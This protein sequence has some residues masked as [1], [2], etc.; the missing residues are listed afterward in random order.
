MDPKLLYDLARQAQKDGNLAEAERLYRQILTQSRQAE[1]LVNLGN[2]LAAQG[3]REEALACHDE[4]LA[5]RPELFEA[6]Y[7]RANLLLELNRA[8]EALQAFDGAIALRP[9]FVSGWN[10]RGTALRRLRKLDEALA[11]F[12]RAAVLA[13]SHVNALTNCAIVLSDLGRLDQALQ[14]ADAA[15]AVQPQSAEAL[16]IK[17][18]ILRDLDRPEEARDCFGRVL[19]IAP[20]HG[21]ALS[22][23]AQVTS[24]LCDWDGMAALAPRLKSDVQEGRSLIQPLVLMAFTEDAA[25]LR[26]CA[27]NYVHRVAPAQKP[28]CGGTP[29]RHER[30]RLA[31]LSAD[32][33]THPTAQLMVELFERHDRARF[34]VSAFAFGPD[35]HSAMRHRLTKAFDSFEDVRHLS[36]LEVARLLRSREIDIAIDLNGHTHEARPGILSHRPAPVQVNYLVYPGTTGARF[37]NYVLADRIVL[38]EDEQR[39]FSEKIIHLPDCYQ[40]N[41]FTRTVTEPPSRQAAGLPDIGFVFCCFNSSWKIAAP[42]FD[43][44]MRLL[45][46]VPDSVLWLLDSPARGNLRKHATARGVEAGRLV[47]APRLDPDRHLARYPLA[48]LFLD[49]LP[50]DAHT[51]CSD[52]LWAGVPVV[53]CYG[54]AFHGRVAASLLK[55]VGLP[56][57]VTVRL[58]DYE[59]LALELA[60]NPALL[61]ATHQK[62]MRNRLTMP[63]FDSDRFRRNIE[64]AYESMLS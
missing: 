23:L 49:T 61:K 60:R 29:Y 15:L 16:Y 35:D 62:L 26:R 9:D 4:A 39:N 6:L 28:L 46:A 18:N 12:S 48:D 27:E 37:M 64:A 51:T 42:Q 22:G 20:G 36:D 47:F 8:E 59:A 30:T 13:P 3:R 44:W 7:N 57:L 56:E 5:A 40:A 24:L 2:V 32:F 58:Q 21:F 33:H 1:V 17:G 50:Y 54:K 41:D 34:E 25:L 63:L 53:T 11:S 55:A 31:Y 52:A 43:V 10:N 38:P 14:A 19:E 45:R